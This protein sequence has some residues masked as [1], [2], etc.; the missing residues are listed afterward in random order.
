MKYLIISYLFY[1]LIYGCSN[2]DS[3]V[4]IEIERVNKIF[5]VNN[6]SF[7]SKRTKQI[8]CFNIVNDSSLTTDKLIKYK[9]LNDSIIE[10]KTYSH[11]GNKYVIRGNLG[12]FN[13]HKF[14]NRLYFESF[15]I[16][17]YSKSWGEI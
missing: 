14:K 7:K 15:I 9:E 12:K 5:K 1:S 10:V 16:K 3:N 13:V 11:D 4:N 8:I 2:C 17:C 6:F